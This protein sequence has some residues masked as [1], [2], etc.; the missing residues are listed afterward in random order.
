MNIAFVIAAILF[1]IAVGLDKAY[2][3]LPFKELKRRARGGHDQKAASVYKMAAHQHS[4][5]VFLWVIGVAAAGT[6][7]VIS[8]RSSWWIAAI[9]IAIAAYLTLAWHP[10]GRGNGWLWVSAAIVS[11]AAAS[12]LNFLRPVLDFVARFIQSLQPVRVHTGLYEKEDLLEL[13]NS[14]KKQADSR[15]SEEEL[16]IARGALTFGDK[17]VADIM[18]P[19]RK[20]KF[21]TASDT[22]GPM[23]MDELHKSGLSRFPVVRELTKGEPS[24]IGTFYI[25]NVDLE[26]MTGSHVK[27]GDLMRRDASFINEEQTLRQALAGFLKTHHHLLV[28]VNQFEEVVGVLSMED[29]I[30]QIL[31]EPII[32]EFD[33]YNDLRAVAGAEAEAE[34]AERGEVK[35]ETEQPSKT[36]VKS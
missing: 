14:Q 29:V 20:V 13:L 5:L 10:R 18:T 24:V 27:V 33:R 8:A 30:E 7:L 11:P 16:K 4:L 15:I 35:E 21:L 1:L 19:R 12:I 31:G 34:R 9:V 22:V 23:L 17:K 36:V 6:L 25:K 3:Q 28:V 32:D 26:D 2:H